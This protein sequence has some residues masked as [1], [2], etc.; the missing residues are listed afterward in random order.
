MEADLPLEL[1][2]L[3]APRTVN[4]H[5]AAGFMTRHR[6]INRGF[7]FCSSGLE[8]TP[9]WS[10]VRHHITKLEG[11]QRPMGLRVVMLFHAVRVWKG[12]QN[13]TENHVWRNHRGY[14]KGGILIQREICSKSKTNDNK[15]ITYFN[16][17]SWRYV[18]Q[19]LILK[20]LTNIGFQILFILICHV[21]I[22]H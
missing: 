4:L 7:K 1:P 22:L 20:I 5:S 21:C 10:S 14:F 16:A 8:W 19:L 12:L 2:I 18:L 3:F 17:L 15:L 13:K 6:I 9:R 11:V